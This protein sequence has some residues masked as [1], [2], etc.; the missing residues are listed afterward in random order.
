MEKAEQKGQTE[1]AVFYAKLALHYY[2][3][4]HQMN[5]LEPSEIEEE[6]DIK[7]LMKFLHNHL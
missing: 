1:L 6:E 7:K 4:Y 3:K 5:G 2:W